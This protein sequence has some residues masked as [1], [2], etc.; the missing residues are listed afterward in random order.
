MHIVRAFFSTNR[1]P[2]Q[3]S[4]LFK[5][6]NLNHI[7]GG[8]DSFVLN[9]PELIEKRRAVVKY[10]NRTDFS[11]SEVITDRI[12]NYLLENLYDNKI[13]ELLELC[14][15]DLSKIDQLL[16]LYGLAKYAE[17]KPDTIIKNRNPKI[18]ECRLDKNST[19]RESFYEYLL[20]NPKGDLSDLYSRFGKLGKSM[21]KYCSM[22]GFTKT[23]G[24]LQST[25]S[26][27]KHLSVP[28]D[29]IQ[30]EITAADIETIF[31]DEF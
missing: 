21:Y 13:G 16:G 17:V 26:S 12:G 19:F 5:S 25:D 11:P 2:F 28:L 15:D 20:D 23:G 6:K 10:L 1:T 22:L 18:K 31:G 14:G 7:K 8:K 27:E 30:A 3:F 24:Q 29:T 4:N 9:N